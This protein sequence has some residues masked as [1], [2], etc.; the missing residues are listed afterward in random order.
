MRMN[1]IAIVGVASILPGSTNIAGFWKHVI[2][3]RDLIGEVPATHWRIE[4][5]YDP[6]P[7]APDKTYC[8]R[9]AFLPA[10]RFD[11]MKYGI[12]PANL[13][14]TDTSQLLGLMVAEAALHDATR[15]RFPAVDRERISVI[16]G[17]TGASE[18]FAD[19]AA[20]TRRPRWEEALRRHGLHAAEVQQISREIA[21]LTV[22]WTEASFPGLLGNVV[23]GR[24]ANRLDLHGT[25]CVVDAACASSLAALSMGIAELV[26]DAA[27]MVLV[28]GIDTM[29]DPMMFM[30]FS[31]TPALSPSG[32]CRPFSDEADG[33]IL[34]EG[35]AMIALRRLEDAE[36]DG[37]PIYAVIR[38]V[39]TSSDGKSKSVY[40]PVH[41]GQ[42]R[43]LRRA[44][45]GAPTL[46]RDMRPTRSSWSRR[47][48]RRPAPGI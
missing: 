18:L 31:E 10:V 23:A 8:K 39:G 26:L 44:R 35:L 36:R 17:N 4:D 41:Q 22:P 12:P 30:C 28:G 40:A 32:D 15:G 38:G 3:K 6:D 42:A 20:R 21:A 11:Y 24:I 9:G 2:E 45:S 34:G 14:S 43:A 5:Y 25:N 27:D 7:S 33:T 1:P 13:S 46:R 37:N 48:A 19:M 29:N 16:L 47:T